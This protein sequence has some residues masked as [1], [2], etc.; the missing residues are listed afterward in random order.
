MNSPCIVGDPIQQLQHDLRFMETLGDNYT[1]GDIQRR[2]YA[3]TSIDNYRHYKAQKQQFD[4]YLVKGRIVQ[5]SQA[6]NV[7]QAITSSIGIASAASS[8]VPALLPVAAAAGV[9]YG[10]YKLGKS[11]QV[12]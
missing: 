3:P 5:R 7:D 10:I 12:W 4:K 8:L 9:G 11:F 2:T 6:P 1:F